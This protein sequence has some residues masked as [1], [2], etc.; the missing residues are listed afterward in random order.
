MNL[1]AQIVPGMLLSGQPVADMMFKAFSL[2]CLSE[3]SRFV[4]DLKLAHYIKVPP[5]AAF[6]VQLSATI[7]VPFIQ[8]GVKQ[9]MFDTIPGICLPKQ[10]NLLT[11]PY[12]NV[13]YSASVLWGLIGPSRQFGTNSIYHPQLYAIIG[14]ALL[15]I[16]IWLWQRRYPN[17]WNKF[18]NTPLI[19][20]SV[21]AIPPATGM[22]YSSY[23]VV[24]FIFQYLI[25]RRNF[26]WWSK[27]NYVTSSALD[28]GT[29]IS[30]LLIFF[31]TGI[32]KNGLHLVWWGNTVF[33]NTAD[34]INLPLRTPPPE[35]I[36]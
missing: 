7:V 4:Q 10:K 11:C 35:G 32:P 12:S 22:N 9:W 29:V 2:Q 24:A 3:G 21:L 28:T 16:P 5:R 18:I 20:T 27:F 31:T 23:F 6:I 13:F 30:V 19:L 33:Q 26:A 34:A 36:S 17:S 25:R 1:L 15:P 14:G 8:L